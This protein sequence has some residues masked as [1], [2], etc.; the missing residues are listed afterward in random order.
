[1]VQVFG[2]WNEMIT[3]YT[4]YP[5]GLWR[6]SDVRLIKLNVPFVLLYCDFVKTMC[7]ERETRRKDFLNRYSS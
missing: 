7:H 2:A 1:M 4:L 6:Y 3:F 5:F